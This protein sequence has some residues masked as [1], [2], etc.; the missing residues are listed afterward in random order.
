MSGLAVTD[1]R[2]CLTCSA[3]FSDSLEQRQHFKL[4]WHRFNLKR[5][6]QNKPAV[7]EAEFEK[8]VEK[9][10]TGSLFETSSNR[11]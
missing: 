11:G 7:D 5:K 3:T 10:N 2:T 4:D 9:S 8:L 1:S 6:I